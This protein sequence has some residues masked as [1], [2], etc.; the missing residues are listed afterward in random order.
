MR[1]CK[2]ILA[3]L[4]PLLF[5]QGC[6]VYM[7]ANQPDKRNMDLF[8]VGTPRNLVMA[9][10]G[11]PIATSEKDGKKVEIYSFVQGYS[12]GAKVGRTIGHGVADV[13]TL[14]LWEVVGT[15]TEATFDGDKT[16]MQVTYDK[17]DRIEEVV[18]LKKK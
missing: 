5:V 3:I 9:E 16:V 13:L 12:T 10:F 4:L 11:L 2:R 15:P 18:A 8:S 6:S 17:D 1:H 14:G 7:A